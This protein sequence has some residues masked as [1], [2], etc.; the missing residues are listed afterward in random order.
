MPTYADNYTSR[1][2]G[3]YISSGIPH[4]MKCRSDVP[5]MTAPVAE[6]FADVM[7][8]YVLSFEPVL[9][10]DWAWVSWEFAPANSDIWSPFA[11][12]LSDTVAGVL[13][14]T[15][16]SPMVRVSACSHS[17]RAAGSKAR[18]YWWGP[19]LDTDNSGT[20]GGDGIV[21]STEVGGLAAATSFATD[22]FRA[23]NGG[24]AIFYERL[25]YKVNDD[26]LKLVRRGVI[27]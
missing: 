5:V 24:N 6:S 22:T 27:A 20:I 23:G 14:H 1:V 4:V 3:R 16:F 8:N 17:G 13:D 10:S 11:P 15:D 25:T 19:L 7:N 2:R 9:P 26:L 21:T 12:V 18:V